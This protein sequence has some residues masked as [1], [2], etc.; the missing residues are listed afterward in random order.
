MKKIVAV[1]LIFVLLVLAEGPVFGNSLDDELEKHWAKDELNKTFLL[2]YFPY[3]GRDSFKR[4]NLDGP[5]YEDEFSL[6]FSS[7]LK[8]KGYSAVEVGWKKELK[9]IDMVKIIGNKLVELKVIDPTNDKAQ[10]PFVDVYDIEENLCKLLASLYNAGI[11]RG[12]S[13]NNFNPYANLT[14]AEAVIVLQRVGSLLDELMPKEEP[15]E[16][17][18]EIP[19]SL[20]GI[21][22]SYSGVENI[23]SKIEGDKVL[24]TATKEFPTP[25]Y[26]V[27][28]E[29]IVKYNG[30]IKIY[31]NITPPSKESILPQVLT[32][33]TISIVIDKG[34][35]GE[36]PYNF[37][38]G[39]F[40]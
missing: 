9:R 23:I 16:E 28:L 3:I 2:Y 36:P 22:Q 1:L 11:V 35:L 40:Y 10:L 26:S 4:L 18:I 8:E 29:K 21:V 34:Y 32:Y 25:G 37:V 14:Q 30:E 19:F 13:N 39:N 24:V 15:V 5:I 27:E 17:P 12:Q 6:S 20:S 38:W 31:I 33:K 7:L